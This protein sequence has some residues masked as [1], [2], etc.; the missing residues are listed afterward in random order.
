MIARILAATLTVFAAT[1]AAEAQPSPQT[2]PRPLPQPPRAFP[3]DKF[4]T[5]PVQGGG[6]ATS[7]SSESK[8][9]NEPQKDRWE[10]RSRTR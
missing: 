10:E 8:G 1:S 7:P 3:P 6:E 9:V 4:S 5:K 2:T